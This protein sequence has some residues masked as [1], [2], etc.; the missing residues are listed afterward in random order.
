[1]LMFKKKGGFDTTRK[2]AETSAIPFLEHKV[3]NEDTAKVR[4]NSPVE[5]SSLHILHV[6]DDTCFSENFQDDSWS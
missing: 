5:P 3:L 4:A 1:M 2:L 6:D